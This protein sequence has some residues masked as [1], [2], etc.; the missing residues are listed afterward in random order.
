L[1]KTKQFQQNFVSGQSNLLYK[2]D[3]EC[4]ISPQNY[5]MVYV[6]QTEDLMYRSKQNT[7]KRLREES[8]DGKT[9][10][11][12]R[13]LANSNGQRLNTLFGNISKLAKT[14]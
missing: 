12:T 1:E 5:R 10:T 2:P 8:S 7:K 6:E 4:L 9:A 11:G 13:A 3:L 14:E